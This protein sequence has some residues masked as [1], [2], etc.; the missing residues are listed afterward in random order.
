MA[1][2]HTE[3]ERTLMGLCLGSV[4]YCPF[5]LQTSFFLFFFHTR[6]VSVQDECLLR[7]WRRENSRE[8]RKSVQRV[9]KYCRRKEKRERQDH[10]L[11]G[12]GIQHRGHRLYDRVWL[13]CVFS[14]LRKRVHV[15]RRVGFLFFFFF[16]PFF[17]FIQYNT[18][19][20][21]VST[22]VP[23]KDSMYRLCI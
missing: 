3:S 7:A 8:V 4:H 14:G 9:R 17:F 23:T 15:S 19:I 21:H 11:W 2:S 18:I 10:A 1:Y 12:S 22:P 6:S 5:L 20:E 16:S 13:Y